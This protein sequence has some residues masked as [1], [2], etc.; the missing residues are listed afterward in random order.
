MRFL[1][2]SHCDAV[3][4][5]WCTAQAYILIFSSVLLTLRPATPLR[6]KLIAH[7]DILLILA[8]GLYTYRDLWPLLTFYL[9][10]TDI[11]DSITWS[12]VALLGIAAVVI[13]LIRPRT[14]VPVDPSMVTPEKDVAPEQTASW[15]SLLF[16][17]YMTQLVWKAWHTTALPFD[18]LVIASRA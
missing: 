2:K 13:P 11:N 17:E 6:R 1:C 7:V 5:I 9:S 4:P 15:L 8:F 18:E 3:F 16:H 12:R 10:P 14:Y